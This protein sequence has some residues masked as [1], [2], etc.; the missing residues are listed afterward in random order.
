MRWAWLLSAAADAASAG[1]VR[2]DRL[3]RRAWL[4]SAAAVRRAWLLSA[5]AVRWASLLSA[6]TL[7]A[8]CAAASEWRGAPYLFRQSLIDPESSPLVGASPRSPAGREGTTA[9]RCRALAG[10]SF[11]SSTALLGACLGASGRGARE[12]PDRTRAPELLDL[13]IFDGARTEAG[14]AVRRLIGVVVGLRGPRVEFLFLRDGRASIGVLDLARPS[15][16]R[17]RSRIENSYLR[18]ISRDDPPSTRYLAGDLLAGFAR[19]T[20]ADAL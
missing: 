17:A 20:G 13:A 7:L 18:V 12:A 8:G 6:A 10:R 9:A 15:L 19:P 5:A 1:A 4:R 11:A 16:R 3:M 2:Q 14:G